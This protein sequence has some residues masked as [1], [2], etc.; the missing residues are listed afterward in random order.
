VKYPGA[1]A[2]APNVILASASRPPSRP[3]V[4][5]TVPTPASHPHLF[6]PSTG[7]SKVAAAA[8]MSVADRVLASQ[9]AITGY[10]P[11]K[12]TAPSAAPTVP[13]SADNDRVRAIL[14]SPEAK[15]REALAHGLA[16][17][18]Y[19]VHSVETAEAVLRSTPRGAMQAGVT[20]LY[21]PSPFGG[22]SEPGPERDDGLDPVAARVLASQG[23]RPSA[24]VS[25]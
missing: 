11:G 10:G 16:H 20:D 7:G 12:T 21:C 4:E 1:S 25:R 23:R 6:P 5:G 18:P 24:P 9:R 3:K 17:H 13:A 8:T 15:G 14:A 2:R 19:I 22:R